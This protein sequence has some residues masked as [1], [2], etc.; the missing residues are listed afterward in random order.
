MA[1]EDYPVDLSPLPWQAAEWEHLH[2]ALQ[3]D[4]LHHALLLAGGAGVGKSQLAMVLAH[5]LI[6]QTQAA[7]SACGKCKS[8]LL[9]KAHTH[10]D[11]LLVE[12][13]SPG[14][15]IRID[16][17]R[18]VNH[19]LSQTA[20]QGGRKV[21]V[22]QPAEAMNTA[23]ANALL[24]NLEE[25]AGNAHIILVSHQPSALLS[26][27]KSRCRML[28]LPEPA[29][30]KVLPWLEPQCTGRADAQALLRLAGGAPLKARDLLDDDRLEQ[31]AALMALMRSLTAGEVTALD[32]AGQWL[33]MDHQQM[34]QWLQ[35]WLSALLRKLQLG[36]GDADI[37]GE[38]LGAAAV[39]HIHRYYDK[40]A[41]ARRALT[42]GANPNAQLLLEELALD[43]Q[44]L[45]RAGLR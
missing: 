45:C 39:P 44:A 43:W 30:D 18:Q 8:C 26:T 22:I 25:P 33:G 23:S 17:V 11:L 6:C 38:R 19:F 37:P 42:S 40:L 4:R 13:E 24:K 7:F 5:R 31:H 1:L 28:L 29:E 27:I 36:I 10:P 12:P 41:R 21:V 20:Q 16:P 34:L 35:Y 32:V 15:A 3:A 9:L 2:S 14:K